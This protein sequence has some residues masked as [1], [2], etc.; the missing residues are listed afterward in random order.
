VWL[1]HDDDN[2]A[3]EDECDSTA[4]EEEGDDRREEEGDDS[5]EGDDLKL[6][7]TNFEDA[8]SAEKEGDDSDGGNF[9]LTDA[10]FGDAPPWPD[11]LRVPQ[12][13]SKLVMDVL[14]D[15]PLIK[16]KIYEMDST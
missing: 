1:A 3:R 9:K 11:G 5:E 4:R 8:N 14:R 10:N 12:D 15:F 13:V 2:C 6:T 16:N 7:G